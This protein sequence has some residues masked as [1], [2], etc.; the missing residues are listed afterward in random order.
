MKIIGI[1]GTN[2][3]GKDTIANLLSKKYGF[4]AASA[5]EMLA[6]ELTN[7]GQPTERENKRNLSA[8]WRRESGLGVIVD[9]AVAQAKVAGFDKLVV[10][11]LR[12]S[13]EVDRVHDLGGE[14]IWVDSDPSVRYARIQKAGRGRVE[15]QK[16]YEQFLAE[17]ETEMQ[18]TG[19]E[20]TLNMAGV[21]KRADR[22]LDNNS[23]NIAEFELQAEDKLRDL[24]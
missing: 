12:N 15:D 10:G 17:E 3:S 18:H 4:Y 6:E 19:D 21:K 16:S 22:F 8:Q 24:L 13:G 1:S 9:K 11:S 2:G 5:T 14:V 20:A 7:R 23:N